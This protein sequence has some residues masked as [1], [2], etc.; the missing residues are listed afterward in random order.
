MGLFRKKNKEE[1]KGQGPILQSKDEI[2]FYRVNTVMMRF[3]LF[4]IIF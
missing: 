4:V 1:I 2:V 3:S